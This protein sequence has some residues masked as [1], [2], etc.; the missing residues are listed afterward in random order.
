MVISCTINIDVA[1]MVPLS[2]D[3]K[4]NSAPNKTWQLGQMLFCADCRSC[5][6]GIAME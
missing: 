6:N 3:A 2:G 4:D 1:R 5:R